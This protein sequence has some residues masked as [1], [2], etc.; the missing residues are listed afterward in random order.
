[1]VP[2][3]TVVADPLGDGTGLARDHRL[4]HVGGAVDDLAI[5][6][7]PRSWADEHDIVHP[8]RAG[9]HLLRA[10]CNDSLGGVRQQSREGRERAL[11]LRD[12]SHLEPVAEQH[13]RDQGGQLPPD[14]D[15]EEAESAG[16][17]GHE[18]HDDRQR[19]Q[20]HHPGLTVGQLALGSADEDQ[21]AVEE[22]DRPEDRR[23]VLDAG[24]ASGSC[25]RSSP[26]P[27]GSTAP[28]GWSG[29]SSA[30][31][32]RGTWPPSGR[33][34]GHVR[35]RDRRDGQRP[36]TVRDASGGAA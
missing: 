2:A 33:R 4:V 32:C 8:Q 16:Q 20:G 11:R 26:R 27:P 17:R 12:R 36:W 18:G 7:D 6:R 23:H 30:R 5:G 21:T 35:P 14:L 3:M 22:D 1:M 34:A 10:I 13:D 25:S 19:D 24:D 29:Q 31:T 9:R 15:L 28:S